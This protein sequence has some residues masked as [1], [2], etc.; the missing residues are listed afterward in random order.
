[1]SKLHL[2][3]IGTASSAVAVMAAL[4]VAPAIADPVSTPANSDF[5]GVGS[6]TT[7][8]MMTNLINGATVNGAHVKGW[9]ET[10]PAGSPSLASF[11]ACTTPSAT[12]MYPCTNNGTDKITLRSG[13]PSADATIVRPDGSGA[14][15]KLL[16]GATNN[17]DVTFAR[18]SSAIDSNG[19]AAGLEMYP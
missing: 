10:K 11:D 18:S 19:Q 8:Y 9:N 12:V 16:Y 7:Q 13:D 1:M 4:S 5:V 15:M 17:N 14:G 6:D 2:S 3:R